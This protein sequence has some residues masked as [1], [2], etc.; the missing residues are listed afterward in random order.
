MFCKP[1]VDKNGRN[2]KKRTLKGSVNGNGY[3][4]VDFKRSGKRVSVAIHR[5]VALALLITLRIRKRLIILT[6]SRLIIAL[7]I[8]SGAPVQKIKFT[9]LKTNFKKVKKAS[10][11]AQAS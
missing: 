6:A 3:N 7:V 9:P 5:L 10:P 8:L 11:I 4:R 2:R 1:Y